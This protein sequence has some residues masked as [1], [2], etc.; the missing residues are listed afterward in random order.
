MRSH[1]GMKT[2]DCLVL[3]KVVDLGR[4]PW[5]AKDL[6][7]AIGL[8]PA[9]VSMSLERSRFAKLLDEGKRRVNTKAFLDFL[10]HGLR[11]VFPAQLGGIA[12]GIPTAWSTAPLAGKFPNASPVVW[13]SEKGTVRGEG[14]LPLYPSVPQAA[15]NSASLHE[16]LALTDTLRIGRAR[17]V[18]LANQILQQ[19]FEG[20][21]LLA[22]R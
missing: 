16:L 12:R 2:Q 20:Y 9:E 8:S 5:M 10:V 4:D 22:E 15:L 18:N 19:R 17:E 3:L 14:I 1:N 13:P 7:A 21:A 11:V 6:A